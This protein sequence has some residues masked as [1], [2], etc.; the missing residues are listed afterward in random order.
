M[1][2]QRVVVTVG[3]R[4][5]RSTMN[6]SDQF[7]LKLQIDRFN[8]TLV[9]RGVSMA[10]IADFIAARLPNDEH[11]ASEILGAFHAV[12]FRLGTKVRADLIAEEENNALLVDAEFGPFSKAGQHD[13]PAMHARHRIEMAAARALREVPAPF[14]TWRCAVLASKAKDHDAEVAFL[15][16]YVETCREL[17]FDPAG[18]TRGAKIVERLAKQRPG[19]D[20]SQ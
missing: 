11:P 13:E 3:S 12:V 15:A 4:K 2:E 17:G 19:K 16:D 9:A 7:S 10:L 8:R 20:K 6:A 1:D 18:T 14:W 5:I